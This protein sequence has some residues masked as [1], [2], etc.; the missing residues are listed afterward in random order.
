MI[1]VI[2][3]QSADY[4]HNYSILISENAPGTKSF[5]FKLHLL[6]SFIIINDEENQ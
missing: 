4:F 3:H 1:T 5:T 2:I 6:S